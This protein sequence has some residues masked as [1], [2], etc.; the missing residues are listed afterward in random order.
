MPA[1]LSCLTGPY[2]KFVTIVC[3]VLMLLE[4][5]FGWVQIF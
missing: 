2:P 3:K 1:L 5:D 4:C